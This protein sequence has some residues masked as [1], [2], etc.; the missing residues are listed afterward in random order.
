MAVPR[1]SSTYR[2]S[3]QRNL[4]I[5]ESSH[6]CSHFGENRSNLDGGEFPVRVAHL[7]EIRGSALEGVGGGSFT[8]A[9]YSMTGRTIGPICRRR[10][11]A[12][13]Q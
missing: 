5:D 13:S 12:E 11:A 4:E 9:V 3:L 8:L 2:A 10:I 7:R 1:Y 6:R